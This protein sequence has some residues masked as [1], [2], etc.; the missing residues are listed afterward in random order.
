MPLLLM[1]VEYLDVPPAVRAEINVFTLKK[2]DATFTANLLNQLFGGVSTG[3]G[4]IQT[5]GGGGGGAAGGGGAGAGAGG[6]LQTT[7]SYPFLV[8]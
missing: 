4:G 6:P 1:L 8:P 2:A 7:T 3:V 5:P